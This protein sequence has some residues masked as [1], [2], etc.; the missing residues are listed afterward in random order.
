LAVPETRTGYVM[1]NATN[2]ASRRRLPG[3][4]RL[5]R[6]RPR[7]SRGSPA[8][9]PETL[10]AK[11]ADLPP[12]SAPFPTA[13]AAR[14]VISPTP[15]RYPAAMTLGV[16]QAR[17]RRVPGRRTAQGAARS[18]C[19]RC[20]SSMAGCTTPAASTNV[21][22]AR[23]FADEPAGSDGPHGPRRL[24]LAG[25]VGNH[26]CPYDAPGDEAVR[27]DAWHQ[28]SA[29]RTRRTLSVSPSRRRAAATRRPA[30]T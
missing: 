9:C 13:L 23:S 22:T 26:R 12:S 7:I 24:A 30:S 28:G 8:P 10:A 5:W 17:A 2:A 18:V 19:L 29:D 14:A 4:P 21:S 15:A 20:R 25:E 27:S 6:P 16:G 1:R 3:S 11:A